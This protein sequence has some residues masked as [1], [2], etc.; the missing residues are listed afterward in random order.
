[1]SKVEV[2][3]LCY[4][5]AEILPYTLRHY[6]TF[7]DKVVV[8][9]AFST[10][11]SADVAR[12]AG[13]VVESWGLGGVVNDEEYC[14]LKNACWQGTDAEWVIVCDADE[15]IYFPGGAEDTLMLYDLGGAAVI[16]PHGFEMFNEVYP[17]TPG[18]IYDEVKHGAPDD[19]WYSKPIL[20]NPRMVE[21]SGFGVGS[22]DSWPVLKD[23]RFLHCGPHWLKP[24]PACYLLHFHQIGP[25]ERIGSRYDA[26]RS[27][28]SRQNKAHGWG[29]LK[30][31]L[32]HAQE[33]RNLIIPRLRQ[34]VR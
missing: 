4:N 28:M 24:D 17:T 23:G 33:K 6:L 12:S 20:F 18:Q 14:A 8:H 21:D 26:V 9:D 11:G 34:V 1:M 10:D 3:V 15:L 2:H 19:K 30:D 7:A 25:I 5:E 27:R 31:G 16:K 22:H 13:A 32:V 29:N